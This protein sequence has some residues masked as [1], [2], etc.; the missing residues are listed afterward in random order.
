M[1]GQA[2]IRPV[3]SYDLEQIVDLE[4]RCFPFEIA[5]SP[6]QLE[7]LIYRANSACFADAI[8]EQLRGFIVV[9]FRSKSLV[10]G[11]ETLNVDPV[12]RGKGIGRRLLQ[13]AEFDM[14]HRGIKRARLEVS[15]GNYGA[16]QL[17]EKV[18]FEHCML[19]KDYYYFN[20]YGSR[21]AYRMVKHL[22]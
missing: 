8:Q 18:G 11:I 22:T 3:S 16:L 7:Y 19:L 20:H 13:V 4:R 12:F 1:Y 17:Y 10:A 14:V 6:R 21:D 2:V 5:Y 9:L 15:T